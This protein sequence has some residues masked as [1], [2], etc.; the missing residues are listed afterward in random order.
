MTTLMAGASDEYLPLAEDSAAAIG[1]RG[2]RTDD[3]V[4]R[5]SM[6]LLKE[7]N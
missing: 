4:E 3:V 6:R 2:L 1:A 7:T 5:E